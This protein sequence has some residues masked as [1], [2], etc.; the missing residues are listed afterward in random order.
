VD[1]VCGVPGD[2]CT[3]INE[4][5]CTQRSGEGRRVHG[6]DGFNDEQIAD[7]ALKLWQSDFFNFAF[8][9]SS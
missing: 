9:L 5:N 6:T 7:D 1:S 4:R 3:R 8:A 2:F